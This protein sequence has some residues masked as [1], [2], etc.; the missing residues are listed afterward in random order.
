MGKK[1]TINRQDWEVVGVM[2]ADFAMPSQE[3]DLW[4]PWDIA[5]T[6][7]TQRF[8]EGPPRDWRFLHT[9]GRLTSGVTLEQAQARLAS[10]YDGLAE[11]YPK[12]NRGWNA[13]SIRF[14]RK[15]SVRVA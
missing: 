4:I 10:F 5:R 8:P 15:L 7:G 2:A 3:T 6:Y 11:R 12:T 1:I 9:L 14:M 13:T